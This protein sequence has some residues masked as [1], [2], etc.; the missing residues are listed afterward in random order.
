MDHLEKATQIRNTA[1]ARIKEIQ[2]DGGL[3]AVGRG[4]QIREVRE[5]ANKKLAALRADSV[6]EVNARRESLRS[7]LF[8]LGHRLSATESEKI[9]TVMSY[10]DA[11]FRAEA[12]ETPDAALKA[13]L[14][15][16]AIGDHQLAMAIATISHE[17]GWH[18]VVDSFVA[19]SQGM[20]STLGE[21]RS[22]EEPKSSAQKFRET[23]SFSLIPETRAEQIA[24]VAS[25][26]TA[27]AA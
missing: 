11:L 17:R 1:T 3:S 14:R 25:H 27:D 4:G 21:L 24:R 6:G 18:G 13:L 12:F 7:Q 5:A 16:R 19:D 26:G 20:A 9:A 22:L 2:V 8:G 23:L 10:R 15:S